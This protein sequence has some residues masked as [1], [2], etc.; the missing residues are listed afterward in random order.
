MFN[1]YVIVKRKSANHPLIKK[2]IK[3]HHYLGNISRGNKYVYC[4]CI[5]RKLV[6]VA[7]YGEP[8]GPKVKAKYGN[9]VELKRF[10]L[11]PI[12]PKNT[13]SWFMAKCHK[14]LPKGLS[15][16]SYANPEQ[17]HE[18]VV[19]RAANFTYLGVQPNATQYVR[20]ITTGKLYGCRTLYGELTKTSRMLRSLKKQGLLKPYTAPKKHVFLYER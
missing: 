3:K 17:G 2:F 18:G 6:G 20:H 12:C 1:D 16:I 19:Y 5:N 13:A 14:L 8:V 4:L 15:V 7:L 9:V 10:A 11:S